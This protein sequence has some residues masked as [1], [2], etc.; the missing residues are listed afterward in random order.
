MKRFF[1]LF[2]SSLAIGSAVQAQTMN[3]EA[4]NLPLDTFWNGS[5]L[6][7]KYIE[8][9]PFSSSDSF[10]AYN[11]YDTTFNYW[12][13]GIAISSMTDDSTGNFTNLYSSIAGGGH[14]STSYG[15]VSAGDTSII[16]TNSMSLGGSPRFMSLYVSNTTYAYSSMM[17]GDSFAKKFG[18]TS[19]DDPDYFFIR[20][21]FDYGSPADYVDFYLADFRSA[22]NSLD[23][24]LDEWVFVDLNDYPNS[25]YAGQTI[26]MQLFSSDTGALGINTPTYF[27]VDDIEIALPGGV[28]KTSDIAPKMAIQV[29]EG[30]IIASLPNNATFQLL[31]MSGRVMQTETAAASVEF[32]TNSLPKGVYIVRASNSETDTATKI[33]RW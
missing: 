19:G 3:F 9:D 15:V 17:N 16:E 31:D 33:W 11:K 32:E 2:L 27:C 20:F 13:G 30:S 5:D 18:G 25:E 6:S 7:G 12:S 8:V 4:L 28:S 26:N 1:T 10:I 23:Y 22:D 21:S 14:N 24:I 29:K